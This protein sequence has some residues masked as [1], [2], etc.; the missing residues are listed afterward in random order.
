MAYDPEFQRLLRAEQNAEAG[1]TN[2]WR[3]QAERCA[4]VA[5]SGLA[6]D[7]RPR[8]DAF[9][10]SQA[11]AVRL[12]ALRDWRQS[13]RGGLLS[14][15]TDAERAVESLRS[16]MAR[17]LA[18]D[19]RRYSLALCELEHAAAAART[20]MDAAQR[21]G[22]SAGPCATNTASSNPSTASPTRSAD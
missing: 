9:T 15:L 12:D 10:L 8:R 2:E 4:G 22:Q 17:R 21:D 14:A 11:A 7:P 1:R 13:P 19:D 16:C 6:P 18:L 5:W 20:A 3:A